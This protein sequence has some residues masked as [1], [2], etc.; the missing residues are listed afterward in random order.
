[1]VR[2]GKGCFAHLA[3]TGKAT[4]EDAVCNISDWDAYGG[5]AGVSGALRNGI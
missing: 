3:A 2:Y 4:L 5:I 1:M